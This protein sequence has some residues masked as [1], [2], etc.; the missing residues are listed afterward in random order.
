[1]L[2]CGQLIHEP[3]PAPLV[4]AAT[5]ARG[6]AIVDAIA[7]LYEFAPQDGAEEPAVAES[8]QAPI[9]ELAEA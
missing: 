6:P 9:L 7:R 8:G 3:G 4:A 5:V 1:M 2:L